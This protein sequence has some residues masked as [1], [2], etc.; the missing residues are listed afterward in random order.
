MKTKL[1]ARTYLKENL[2][3]IWIKRVSVNDKVLLKW[4]PS[5]PNLTPCDFLHGLFETYVYMHSIPSRLEELKQ[6]IT[7]VLENVTQDRLQRVSQEL[8]Y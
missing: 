3:G 4:P 7:V 8:D 6:R 5:S 2:P 1:N